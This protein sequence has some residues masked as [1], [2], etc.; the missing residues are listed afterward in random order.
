MKVA[1]TGASGFVGRRLLGFL[2]RQGLEISVLSR[3]P[4]K[5]FP[6]QVR[7]VTGDLRSSDC[8]NEA[9]LDGADVLVHCAGEIRDV[10]AMRSV[11]VG[12]TQRL[13]E[14]ALAHA[15]RRGRPMH[16]V[17]LSSVGAYG[18][19]R[20]AASEER[21]VTEESALS[22]VGEYEV[23]KTQADELLIEASQSGPLSYSIVRPSNVFGADMPNDS[24]RA[25]GAMV[26]R[27]FFFYIG[28]PGAVATYVHV[29]DIVETI[30]LCASDD[31]AKGRVYNVSNDC[32]I[33]AMIGGLAGAAGVK[34][35]HWRLP[36]NLVRTAAGITG[37]LVRMPLTQERITA[38]VMRTRYPFSKIE[39]ELGFRPRIA[40]PAAIGEVVSRR[41]NRLAM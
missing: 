13:I 40:V 9:L 27:G 34:A 7:V 36:E 16:W 3:S 1:I 35:P 5:P 32:S 33:E 17:Q 22:P 20:G 8:P 15:A 14:S 12:G 39:R 4:R 2:L 26:R 11:H 23:T 31:R 10:A 41:L 38:L 30:A 25:L 18:P 6:A 37:K 21:I 29:D 28:P 24:L 19:P